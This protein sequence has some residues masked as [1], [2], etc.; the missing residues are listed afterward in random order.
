MV[1]L[2]AILNSRGKSLIQRTYR[3]NVPA[4]APARFYARVMLDEDDGEAVPILADDDG[5]TYIYIRHNSLYFLAVTDVNASAPMVLL[6]LYQLVEVLIGY[7]KEV[8]QESITDNFVVIYE[9]LDEMMDF[10][11]PQSTDPSVL[12]QYITQ[13]GYKLTKKEVSVPAAVTGAVSWRPEGIKYKRNEVFLDVI[14]SIN[15]LVASSGTLLRSEIVGR[16]ALNVKLSGMPELRLGLNDR[17][18]FAQSSQKSLTKKKGSIEMEDVTFHQCVK[19]SKFETNRTISFVPP[20]GEFEL[21][22]YRLNTQVKPLIWIEAI[23][24]RHAH[25]RV[26]YMV[27]AKA[28][29]KQ[30]STANNVRIVVP[31][32]PNADSPKLK[33]SVGKCAYAPDQ[34]AVVWTIKQFQGGREFRMRAQF[35][36]PSID[37]ED[38]KDTKPP[39]RVEFEIPYFTVSGIQI[40]F[41]KVMERSGYTAL[42]WCRYITQSGDYEIRV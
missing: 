5:F 10:G 13:E 40:R 27:K 17:V 34:D 31:V 18:R 21:M 42:P 25:S 41:L 16:I 15:L 28:Q 12:Q 1:S 29:F 37:D 9:L 19:L 39:I 22:S 35:G 4:N 6:Y 32:P 30:R 23:V 14:E 33:S 26:E 11:Y 2:V 3:G 8:E 24:E 36:L 38:N 7:F 20:D